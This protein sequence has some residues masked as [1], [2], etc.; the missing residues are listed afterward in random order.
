[1]H[2][3]ELNGKQYR[4]FEEKK[5]YTYV[6]EETGVKHSF[7]LRRIYLWNQTSQRRTCGLAWVGDKK[8]NTLD[9]AQGILSRWGASENT[10][11]HLNN[12][13]PFHY[14]PG[15]KLVESQ[16][17]EISNPAIKEKQTVIDKLVKELSKFYKKLIK[18]KVSLKNNKEPRKNSVLEKLK[19]A[20]DEKESELEKLRKEKNQLPEKIDVSTLED[21]CSFKKV[22][23]EGK[24]LFDF[25]TCSVWNARKKMIDWL[26]PFF[27]QEDE[28]VD[29]FYAITD[30]H[31]WIKITKKEVI[32]RLESL[33]QPRRRAAQEQLCRQ[34]T[35][36]RARI[37]NGKLLLIEVGETPL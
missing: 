35:S 34:L 4:V 25:V 27:K 11:K 7:E 20:I 13:H 1:L 18:T 17:Q 36:L 10:F 31:G 28:L 6:S 21:Y 14:H 2:P 32:V 12:R 26:Q 8:M 29:L 19:K 23:N 22:D 5:S 16:R 30:S 37:P 3:F 33:Q 9:C 24:N 15:F